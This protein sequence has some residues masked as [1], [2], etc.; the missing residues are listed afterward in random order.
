MATLNCLVQWRRVAPLRRSRKMSSS[1]AATEA[2]RSS[3]DD[4]VAW[5]GKIIKLRL[6]NAYCVYTVGL[7]NVP[8]YI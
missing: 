5:K 7:K 8:I 1:A 6:T 4:A 2:H 3:P